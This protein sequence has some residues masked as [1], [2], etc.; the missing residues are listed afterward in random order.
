MTPAHVTVTSGRLEGATTPDG[1]VRAFLGVPYAAPPVGDLRWRPPHPVR[2]WSGTRPAQRFAPS[3][4]QPVVATN[5]LYSG[6][7]REFSEDCLYL[8]VWTGP[9]GDTGRPV[10]VWL[11]FGGFQFGS[12]ANPLYDG[13][14]L[15]RE[16]AT[17]VSINYRLGRLGFLAHPA[18]SAESD[19]GVSGNYGML[20][21]LAALRWVRDNIEAFGGDPARVTLFGVS[22]GGHSV[23]NL[24]A[25]E[26]ADGLFHRAAAH[27]G[28]GVAPVLDGPGHPANPQTLAAGEQAGTELADLLG[29]RTAAQLRALP[30]ETLAAATLPRANGPWSFELLPGVRTSMHVFDSAYPVVDGYVLRESPLTA[31][32]SGRALD[33]PMIVGNVGNEGSGLPCLTTLPDYHE[34]AHRE[35]G[36]HADRLLSLYPATSD[37][38]VPA[39]SRALEGDRVFVWSNWTAARLQSRSGGSPIWHYGFLRQP[40]ISQ[41]SDLVEESFAAAFHGAELPYLFGTYDVWKWPWTEADR[42]LGRLMRGTWLAFARTGDPT[43]AEDFGAE[44]PLWPE[45]SADAPSTLVWD[46]P[47]PR[48]SDVV[49]HERMAAFDVVNGVAVGGLS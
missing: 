44:I 1:R 9:S 26:L 19:R 41:D 31:Y 46:L 39:A 32:E 16:G 7:E 21:Q 30:A 37:A 22:A 47:G 10:L 20:D 36:P 25:S 3:A 15:A 13:A 42:A 14:V 2:P 12:G 4:P 40:P 43:V 45:F 48:V 24:R 35:Y 28:P 49:S 6:G 17:V 33:V 11:H 18:L 38:D 27:S 5:S 8:N 23:H 34:Y 29:A